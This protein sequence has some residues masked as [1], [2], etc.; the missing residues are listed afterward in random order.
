MKYDKRPVVVNW[1]MR[2]SVIGKKKAFEPEAAGGFEYIYVYVYV[3]QISNGVFKAS[4]VLL[5]G[6]ALVVDGGVVVTSL[7]GDEATR[8]RGRVRTTSQEGWAGTEMEMER[9]GMQFCEQRGMILTDTSYSYSIIDNR[10]IF[11]YIVDIIIC[12]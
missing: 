5:A 8:I 1:P 10:D 11:K 12:I 2:R 4:R 6:D 3:L 7:R 9:Y